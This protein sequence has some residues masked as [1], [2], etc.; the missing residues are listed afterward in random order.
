MWYCT[1]MSYTSILNTC[2]FLIEY[3]VIQ[4]K[5]YQ[6]I[7]ISFYLSS[8]WSPPRHVNGFNLI[9]GGISSRSTLMKRYQISDFVSDIPPLPSSIIFYIYQSHY[10]QSSICV[11]FICRCRSPIV[12][13]KNGSE[14]FGVSVNSNASQ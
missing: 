5:T 8:I 2:I 13:I 3:I 1:N 11:S 4:L 12:L 14:L 10:S 6:S 9:F 7:T